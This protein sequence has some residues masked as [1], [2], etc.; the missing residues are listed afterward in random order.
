MDQ[1]AFELLMDR[2]QH[3]E[4]KINELD[5]KVSELLT[6]KWKLIGMSSAV[7]FIGA[8]IMHLLLKVI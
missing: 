2:F 7:G 4:N 8:F 6:F 3:L 5:H 1:Q